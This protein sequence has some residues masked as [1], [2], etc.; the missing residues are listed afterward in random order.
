MAKLIT[1][2]RECEDLLD[3][4]KE[5]DPDFNFS[6]FV[7]EA[8]TNDDTMLTKEQLGLKIRV[9]ELEAEKAQAELAHL[10]KVAPIIEEKAE[11]LEKKAE[12][13]LKST[14]E[15]LTRVLKE[16]G[17]AKMQEFLPKHAQI[18]GVHE[19]KIEAA[20]R[21]ELLAQRILEEEKADMLVKKEAY[22][23]MTTEEQE[24]YDKS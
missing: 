21:K 22:Q 19:E 16:K 18:T 24:E 5:Q 13:R 1:L 14:V 17:E 15:T 23:S 11:V 4:W 12:E 10:K 2:T 3:S 8:M 7:Q 9:A 20:V 6:R